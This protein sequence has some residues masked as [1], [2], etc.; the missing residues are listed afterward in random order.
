MFCEQSGTVTSARA[1]TWE[2][3]HGL[4]GLKIW[5]LFSRVTFKRTR[6]V[7][8]NQWNMK[9]WFTGC[10]RMRE[11]IEKPLPELPSTPRVIML[12]VKQSHLL[13]LFCYSKG[14]S[15]HATLTWTFLSVVSYNQAVEGRTIQIF[16]WNVAFIVKYSSERVRWPWTRPQAA[17]HC[18]DNYVVLW[19]LL[20]TSSVDWTQAAL[21]WL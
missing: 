19:V 5:S 11:V 20:L 17:T 6:K 13:R 2:R 9:C 10:A 21:I 14:F 1:G 3:A 15:A 12:I 18:L 16:K 8:G 7:S 4:F